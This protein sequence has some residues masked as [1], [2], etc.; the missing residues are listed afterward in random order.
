MYA[1][2]MS[3]STGASAIYK[4]ISHMITDAIDYYT[5]ILIFN[6]FCMGGSKGA[7]VL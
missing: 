3:E 4:G 5:T 1:F 2:E 7:T 6:V